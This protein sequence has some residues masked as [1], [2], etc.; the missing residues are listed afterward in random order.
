MR[1]E[2]V[3]G[4]GIVVMAAALKV[5]LDVG[6]EAEPCKVFD[7]KSGILGLASLGVEV[8]YTHNQSSACLFSQQP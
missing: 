7:N 5:G 8:L 3:E 6:A 1:G 4:R 2:A